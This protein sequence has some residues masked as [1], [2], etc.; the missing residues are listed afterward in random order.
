MPK[1]DIVV[2]GGSSGALV[3][4]TKIVSKLPRHLNAAVF[5]VVHV[6]PTR[7]SSIP[8]ILTRAGRLEATHPT[9]RQRIEPG[10]IYVAPPDRHMILDDGLI[11][12]VHGPKENRSRPAIDPLF[13]SAAMNYASRVIGVVLSGALDDGTAGLRAIKRM[14]GVAIVQDPTDADYPAMPESAI[15]NN[16]IDHIVRIDEIAPL[17]VSLSE[18]EVEQEVETGS[19]TTELAKEVVMAEQKLE[20]S[21]MIETVSELG[22]LS[23]F[24][25][26]ECHGSLWE[27]QDGE[28]LRYRCHVGHAYTMDSLD[29]DHSEKLEGALWSAL[30]A[31]EERGALAR[32]LAQQS[33]A[34]KRE[35]LAKGF[36]ERGREADEH[37]EA[38]RKILFAD[39]EKLLTTAKRQ[40]DQDRVSPQ[41]E[42]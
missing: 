31:L 21:E 9:D 33:R 13:R 24:T 26:P 14:G 37:A 11:T 2:I 7:E 41:S 17:L 22:K 19:A 36:E 29:A 18:E 20:S 25:C 10:R 23:M 40:S 27:L 28:L 32:R 3:A 30:R 12:I 38:I 1:R 6:S 39:P 4:L 42:S 34:R 16:S 15:D 5:I 8:Q 35:R